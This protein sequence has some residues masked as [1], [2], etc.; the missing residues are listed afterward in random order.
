M[1]DLA[2][3][4]VIGYKQ[5]AQ[6]KHRQVDI[7]MEYADNGDLA[8][9]IE[10][11]ARGRKHYKE[12]ELMD[13]FA[14]VAKAVNKAHENDVVH[15]DIK[16]ANIFLNKEGQAKLGDFGIA[17]KCGKNSKVTTP[18]GT[19]LYLD[20]QRCQG[21]AY[22]QKADMWSLGCV[23]YE[24]AALKPAFNARSMQELK[25]KVNRGQV[26]MSV[27]RLAHPCGRRCLHASAESNLAWSHGDIN[28]RPCYHAART[29]RKI[30]AAWLSPR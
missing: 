28:A 5:V 4:N 11:R 2:S 20:P 9:E 12:G 7:Y 21:R 10:K 3:T 30:D 24:M 29:R 19:P 23:L 26:D 1:D 27:Q 18:I 8:Q 13:R 17:V 25:S 14:D 16:P 15:R 22:G 6:P